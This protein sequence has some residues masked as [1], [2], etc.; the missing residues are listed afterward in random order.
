MAVCFI[1][2]SIGLA[3][4]WVSLFYFYSQS[5]AKTLFYNFLLSVFF[6]LLCLLLL[7]YVAGFV[8]GIIALYAFYPL[9]WQIIWAIIAFLFVLRTGNKC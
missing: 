5:L 2:G 3:Q 9:I 6:T 7:D 1:V 4:G 8:L